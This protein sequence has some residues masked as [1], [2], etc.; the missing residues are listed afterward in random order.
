MISYLFILGDAFF[1]IM[2]LL[3]SLDKIIHWHAHL[4]S[5]KEYEIIKN[6]TFIKFAVL[7]FVICELFM[8]LSLFFIGVT[9]YNTIVFF[10]LLFIY[11]VAVSINLYKGNLN[12]S[13]GC[14]SVM[15]HDQLSGR[16]IYRN[17]FLMLF[18][19]FLFI[20]RNVSLVNLSLF[21]ILLTGFIAFGI[22]VTYGIIKEVGENI[23]LTQRLL[24]K[25]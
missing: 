1:G 6:P 11:S 22:L 12:I 17:L 10:V 16:L 21:E 24:R 9:Y 15:D 3:T 5:V 25:I 18:Y 7:S 4:A 19:L 20:F 14:G 23:N 2:F 13:C 8:S